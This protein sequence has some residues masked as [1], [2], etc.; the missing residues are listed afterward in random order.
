MNIQL[1]CPIQ[2]QDSL[3]SPV[4]GK[5]AVEKIVEY[6]VDYGVTSASHNGKTVFIEFDTV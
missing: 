2:I 1:Q 6:F 5:V 3:F 4:N